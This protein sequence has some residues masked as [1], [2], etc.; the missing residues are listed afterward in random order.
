MAETE[1]QS[2]IASLTVELLSAYLSNN[3]VP[4]AELA[5][6][7][8]STRAALT[9]DAAPVE[10][11][12][13][14][15][16]FTPAVTARKSLASPDHIISLIDGKPYKTLK[17]HL[18]RHGLTPET[19]RERY[20]LPASYPMVAPAFAAMR[21]AIAEKIGLGTKRA[22][23]AV[24]P[25]DAVAGA[26]AAEA[27]DVAAPVAA[28]PKKQAAKTSAAKAAKAPARK[29]K[30][31]PKKP[32]ATSAETVTAPVADVADSPVEPE[33]A[34]Q[35]VETPSAAPTATKTTAKAPARGAAPKKQPT[36]RMARTP[37]PAAKSEA[38]AP[39]SEESSPPETGA[40]ETTDAPAAAEQ[41]K[42]RGK[43]GL[44]GKEAAVTSAATETPAPGAAK[45]RWKR[46]SAKAK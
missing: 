16:T 37:K 44:F 14:T 23:D 33:V 10:T 9:Q 41:P 45:T 21:R 27:T 26:D 15:P 35:A 3:T 38:A 46:P 28:K 34:Q 7:I 25:A 17:R 43:L 36:K 24:V 39:V 22:A 12:A 42:R 6:L 1:K 29:A 13:D 11:E 31:T 40:A 18:T 20:G 19:Y 32:T 8:Q 2:D 5:G 4:S 30:A